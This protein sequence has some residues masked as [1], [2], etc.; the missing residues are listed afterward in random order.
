MKKI[1]I[2]VAHE[3]KILLKDRQ[4]LA[5]LFLM[6]LALIVF[7]T[8]ALQDVYQSKVGRRMSLWVLP[9]TAVQQ[10]QLAKF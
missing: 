7:L 3:L 1:F 5:L 10:N 9:K 2:I 6:P 4:A 8:L